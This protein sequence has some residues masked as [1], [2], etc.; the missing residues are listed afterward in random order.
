MVP[1][2]G[3]FIPGNDQASNVYE[4]LV[5]PGPVR[6][7]AENL[8]P[9]GIQSPDFPSHSTGTLI[10]RKFNLEHLDIKWGGWKQTKVKVDE[11]D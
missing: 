2:P 8:A 3:R 10:T 5:S 4:D 1:R 6:T 7:G 9:N 11:M